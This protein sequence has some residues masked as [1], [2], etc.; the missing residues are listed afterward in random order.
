MEVLAEKWAQQFYVFTILYTAL[1]MITRISILQ[2]YLRIWREAAVGIWFRRTCWA[3]IW[4]HVVTLSAYCLSFVFQCTPVSYAWTFWS[5][6]IKGTCVNR[7]G[8]IYSLGAINICYDVV[9]FVLPLH[10]FLKLNIS[11]RRKTG[12][13]TIFM[14][15]LLVTICAIVSCHPPFLSS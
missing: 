12:V 15:G 8:Q 5:G 6:L 13:L 2:L 1:V 14:V 9:V 7:Q 4:I 10:N 3:L 11:W